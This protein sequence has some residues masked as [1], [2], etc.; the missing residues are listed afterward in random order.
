MTVSGCRTSKFYNFVAYLSHGLKTGNKK[1]PETLDFKGFPGF[2]AMQ[3][4]GLEPA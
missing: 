1:I 4:A 2:S 3:G